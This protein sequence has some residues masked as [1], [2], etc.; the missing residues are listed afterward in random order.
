MKVNSTQVMKISA[1]QLW[2]GITGN[3]HLELSHPYVQHHR[4]EKSMCLGAKDI[5]IYVN[6]LT[7]ERKFIAWEKGI[8]YDLR[9]GRPQGK[10]RSLVEWRIQS[11][12]PTESS[13]SITVYPD[14]LKMWPRWLRWIIFRIKARKP[15]KTYLDAVTSGIKHWLETGTP[16][17]RSDFPN[18]PW[19]GDT[20]TY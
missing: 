15:L 18:H 1:S 16:V 14:F 10:S 2:D 12:G 5:I 8:G 19:F 17:R 11:L 7:F 4:H 6:G 20:Q 3:G 13:L 9:I